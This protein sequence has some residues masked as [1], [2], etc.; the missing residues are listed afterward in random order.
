MWVAS[1]FHPGQLDASLDQA[2]LLDQDMEIGIG[3]SSKFMGI[4]GNSWEFMFSALL[5]HGAGPDALF[6]LVPGCS[7]VYRKTK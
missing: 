3:I 4:L 2:R 1:F 5:L 6:S 7:L